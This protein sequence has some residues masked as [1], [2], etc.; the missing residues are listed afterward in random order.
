MLRISSSNAR[1]LPGCGIGLL[2]STPSACHARPFPIFLLESAPGR[3]Q[4]PMRFTRFSVMGINY[5][6]SRVS[7]TLSLAE[8]QRASGRWDAWRGVP[9]I[10]PAATLSVKHKNP[11]KFRDA[12]SRP[13]HIHPL[14]VSESSGRILTTAREKIGRRLGF[15][16]PKSFIKLFATPGIYLI[17]KERVGRA[18]GLPLRLISVSGCLASS[19]TIRTVVPVHHQAPGRAVDCSSVMPEKGYKEMKLYAGVEAIKLPT[20]FETN[21]DVPEERGNE[22]LG[23]TMRAARDKTGFT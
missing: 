15:S 22:S 18:P 2:V 20:P 3:S 7:L 5:S 11:K 1:P 12:A 23:E 10:P 8:L 19:R 16:V 17:G 21:G 4:F 14:Q 13:A 9:H 6:E